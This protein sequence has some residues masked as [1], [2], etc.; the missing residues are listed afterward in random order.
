MGPTVN[1][2]IYS[3]G[4][5]RGV[6]TVRLF[7]ALLAAVLTLGCI[8]ASPAEESASTTLATFQPYPTTTLSTASTLFTPSSTLPVSEADK[9]AIC[10]EARANRTVYERC[11]MAASGDLY[12]PQSELRRCAEIQQHAGAY[13]EAIFHGLQYCAGVPTSDLYGGTPSNAMFCKDLGQPDRDQCYL[14]ASM[15]DPIENSDIKNQ[16]LSGLQLN[17]I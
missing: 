17:K 5:S 12:L 2:K 1:M 14:S 11:K 6:G 16:C 9:R 4:I 7:V 8:G 3:G 15:C 13:A 10:L